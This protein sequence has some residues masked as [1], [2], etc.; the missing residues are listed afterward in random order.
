MARYKPYDLQQGKMIALS[1]ADQVMP[2]SFEYALDEI[3]EKYLDLSLFD[4]R[5]RN[6][7]TGRRA[8]DP[9][10]M[11]KIVFYGYY[12]GLI[13]SRDLEEACRRNVVFMALS[14]DT[15][16]HFTTIA[17]FITELEKEIIE[18]FGQ[19][20]MYCDELGLIGKEHFAIDGCKLPSNASKQ[21]SGTLEELRDKQKKMEAAVRQMLQRHRERDEAE[22][23]GR[24]AQREDKKLA[25]YRAKIDKIKRF[26]AEA[27]PNMGPSGK[28]RKSNI[29]DPHSA[30][31]STSH[32][33]I[34][35][36]NGV[37]VVDDKH[38]IVVSA[39][40]HGNGQEQ[41]AV[42]ANGGS[43]TAHA[44]VHKRTSSKQPS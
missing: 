29:T 10:V 7:D 33:V 34:Q 36:Y 19:V 4:K 35:G 13:S 20:L 6:D 2:G 5:Y 30:K 25:T 32:G 39:E 14:A 44:S 41:G 21:W 9:K 8:Y 18:L 11:L 16:P 12:K 17:G 22:K 24:Q 27:K 28:E 40:A 38:Q 1:Y 37:A 3:V 26:L 42:G 15:R 31:M 43:D 23:Q